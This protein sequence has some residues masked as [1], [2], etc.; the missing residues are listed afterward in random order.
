MK[1]TKLSVFIQINTEEDVDRWMMRDYDPRSEYDL[2]D[3]KGAYWEIIPENIEYNSA[4]RAG[5][6]TM[7]DI[8]LDNTNAQFIFTWG[9]PA[10]LSLESFS[11]YIAEMGIG[12]EE[13]F[14]DEED[15]KDICGIED[16]YDETSSTLDDNDYNESADPLYGYG[17]EDYY[18]ED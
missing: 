13:Y 17:E 12:W 8:F 16:D 6:K 15:Y 2:E 10:R 1:T 3:Y 9:Y 5:A 11:S 14:E 4:I 18:G 7:S